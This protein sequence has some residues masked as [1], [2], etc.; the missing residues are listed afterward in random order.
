ML[1]VLLLLLLLLMILVLIIF[2][3][4]FLIGV[5]FDEEGDV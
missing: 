3:L 1:H 4:I 2:G 5:F